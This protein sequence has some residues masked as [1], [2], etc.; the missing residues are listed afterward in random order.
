MRNLSGLVEELGDIPFFDD[1]ARRKQR[2][3]D[4][5]WYSPK[6]KTILEDVIGDLVVVPR[7]EE[8]VLATMKLCWKHEVPLTV[9]GLGTG[10]YGQAMPLKGGV[11]LD[12][13]EFSGV[14]WS[15]PGSV[16][17]RAGTRI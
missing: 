3:R 16:R 14:V 8:E 12:L 6:L 5:F 15:K 10:N 17:V 13:S 11:V 1:Q 2:S 7:T 4:F 9:R